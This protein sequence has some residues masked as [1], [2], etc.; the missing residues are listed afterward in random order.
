MAILES[1]VRLTTNENQE[2]EKEDNIST[3]T[4]NT[5]AIQ[6]FENLDNN[7]VRL[8]TNEIHEFEQP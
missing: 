7:T 5:S 2:L 6:T 8:N 4:L 1:T 3:V